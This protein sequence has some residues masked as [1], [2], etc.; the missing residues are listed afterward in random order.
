MNLVNV[1]ISDIKIHNLAHFF[2]FFY[3]K[4]KYLEFFC[5]YMYLSKFVESIKPFIFLLFNETNYF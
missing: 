4:S 2:Y 1:Q 3:F 5:L